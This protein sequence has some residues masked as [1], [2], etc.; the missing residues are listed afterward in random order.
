MELSTERLVLE[1]LEA[2]HA[3]P[4]FEGLRDERIYDFLDEDPPESL[5]ALRERYAYL[6]RRQSPDGREAWLN[7]AVR[8]RELDRYAG[9]VQATVPPTGVAL[10]AY[11][12]FPP[13]WGEGYAREAVEAMN[14]HLAAHY[15][16]RELRATVDARNA[17]SIALLE[18][19]GFTR[20]GQ[21]GDEAEYRRS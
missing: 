4:L 12:L 3:E 17:R 19:L 13:F 15:A 1:P 7:W 20:T 21:S 9:Y 18:K 14:A 2:R 6:A 10:I 16:V 11:V 8:V 5:E